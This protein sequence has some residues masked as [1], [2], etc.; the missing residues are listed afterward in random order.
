MNIWWKRLIV[1]ILAATAL[2][3]HSSTLASDEPEPAPI[4]ERQLDFHDLTLRQRDGSK[5]NLRQYVSGKQVVIVSFIAGWCKNS[6]ENGHVVKRLYDKYG[7]K[8]LGV[9][10]VAEYSDEQELEQHINRIG[11][12]YPVMIETDNRDARR[13]SI[14]FKYRQAVG[15]KRKW[16]TPF[17][18]ILD[19]RDI[20][21]AGASQPL[22]R[23]VHTV[24]GEIIES[25]AEQFISSRLAGALSK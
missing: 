4:V 22:A 7:D 20:L 10:V 5:L 25:E 12:N 15:D 6:N 17:Y 2:T 14:H 19:A 18:V 1:F 24:S 21:P 3:L 23:R 9:V 8:G 13:K 11:I 16:G